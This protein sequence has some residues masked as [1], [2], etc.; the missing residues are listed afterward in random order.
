MGGGVDVVQ[1]P[2]GSSS[3]SLLHAPEA[4]AKGDWGVG[5]TQVQL[6]IIAAAAAAAAA[7]GRVLF[8][9]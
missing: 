4:I 9:R 5:L 6:V 8:L 1:S 2:G 3:S 7:A